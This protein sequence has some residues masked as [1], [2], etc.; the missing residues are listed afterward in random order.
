[1]IDFGLC[2]FRSQAKSDREFNLWQAEQDEEGACGCVMEDYLKG[3]FI[4]R[5]SPGSER[6][7]DE[8]MGEDSEDLL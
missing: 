7:L 4:Y 8:F 2:V 1:M 5:R 3:G 6:L